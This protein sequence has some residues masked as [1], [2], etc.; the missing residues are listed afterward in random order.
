MKK[1][2]LA[3][4]VLGLSVIAYQNRE[5]E[6]LAPPEPQSV[7]R[8]EP[9]VV[10]EAQKSVEDTKPWKRFELKGYNEYNSLLPVLHETSRDYNLSLEQ[11]AVITLAETMGKSPTTF[12]SAFFKKYLAKPSRTTRKEINSLYNKAKKTQPGISY[13][14]FKRQLATSVGPMQRIYLGALEDGFRGTLEQ[15]AEPRTN[16]E[17]AAYHLKK[18]GISRHSTLDAALRTHNSGSQKGKTAK[19]YLERAESYCNQ[20]GIKYTK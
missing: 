1:T 8:L 13:Q 11:L 2:T 14:S 12:E 17:F 9:Q 19:G 7:S 18:N 15:F 10:F 3:A 20:L 4:I 6:A 5:T 16:I